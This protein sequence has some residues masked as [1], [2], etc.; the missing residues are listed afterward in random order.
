[1]LK[2]TAGFA[3]VAP[4][5]DQRHAPNTVEVPFEIQQIAGHRNL[6]RR[7]HRARCPEQIQ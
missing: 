5:G 3:K 2:K 4:A 7:W 6:S 1:L